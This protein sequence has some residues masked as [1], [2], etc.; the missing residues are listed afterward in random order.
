L[1]KENV[2]RVILVIEYK[3]VP[4]DGEQADQIVDEI[5]KACEV[6]QKDFGADTC[7]I[8]DVEWDSGM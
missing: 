8:D 5:G 6:L 4:A 2:M 7:F 1:I 3:G